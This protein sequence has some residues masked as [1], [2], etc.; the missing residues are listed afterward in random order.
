MDGPDGP[1]AI[2]AL[3]GDGHARRDSEDDLAQT[4]RYVGHVAPFSLPRRI[5]GQQSLL[6]DFHQQ[7]HHQRRGREQGF[8][9]G[10]VILFFQDG[11]PR[12]RT[13]PGLDIVQG[14]TAGVDAGHERAAGDIGFALALGIETP[15]LQVIVLV[16]EV[17]L[18]AGKPGAA[19]GAGGER[20]Q[21]GRFGT[22]T[23]R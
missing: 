4:A 11:V 12:D 22:D 17:T 18:G 1:A 23:Y 14:R 7:E 6:Q 3:F 15:A 13:V 19:L 20:R 10:A 21:T 9:R 5:D 8:E 2:D 16:P